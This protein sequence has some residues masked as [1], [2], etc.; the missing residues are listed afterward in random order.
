MSN[1]TWQ[2]HV[3]LAVE[4]FSKVPKKWLALKRLVGIKLLR[5]RFTKTDKCIGIRLNNKLVE[6]NLSLKRNGR[7]TS[8]VPLAKFWV[9]PKFLFLS[10]VHCD[11]LCSRHKPLLHITHDVCYVIRLARCALEQK[12]AASPNGVGF[13]RQLSCGIHK[14]PDESSWPLFANRRFVCPPSTLYMPHL[15][16]RNIQCSCLVCSVGLLLFFLTRSCP[17]GLLDSACFIFTLLPQYLSFLGC[18][19]QQGWDIC[20]HLL[21]WL[22]VHRMLLVTCRELATTWKSPIHAGRNMSLSMESVI[23]ELPWLVLLYGFLL[24]L[25]KS[26]ISFYLVSAHIGLA[27][28]SAVIGKASCRLQLLVI[29]SRCN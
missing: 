19:G 27:G 3:A 26:W 8:S 20:R 21:A 1:F 7:W 2:N 15:W 11:K 9:V 5:L 6:Q 16:C 14:Q 13:N 24:F 12:V 28:K 29:R 22:V 23:T 10:A 4:P 18:P 17:F 25:H